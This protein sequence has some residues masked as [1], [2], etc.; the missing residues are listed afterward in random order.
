MT[1]IKDWSLYLVTDRGLSMG[2]SLFEICQAAIRGGVSVVQLREKNLD[3]RAFFK[4]GLA[5]KDLLASN[6]IPFIINDRIDIALALDADGVH[7]GQSDIPLQIARKILG[8]EKII[9]WSI[10]S[11]DQILSDEATVADYLAI[12]P[13]FNTAT[14]TDAAQP[15]GIDGMRKARSMTDKPLVAIG[16]IK[17]SNLAEVIAAGADSVAVVSAIVGAEDVESATKRLLNTIINSRRLRD[18][19]S[20]S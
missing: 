7:L 20:G 13:I 2:R 3:S 11:P 19:K 17:E 4:E 5:L 6:R 12:G 10:D 1:T 9:G 8:P 15:W 14:K 18:K 16:G